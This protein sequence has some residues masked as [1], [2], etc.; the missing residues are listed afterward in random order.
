MTMA[1]STSLA[2]VAVSP[3]SGKADLKAFVDFAWEAYKD[4]PAW[5]PPLK[6]EVHG[7]LT[8]GK[9]PFFEHAEAQ[10]F[11][12][13]RDGRVTGRISAHIDRL[14]LTMPS[15]QGMGPGTGNWGMFEALDGE[16]AVALIAAA[17]DW[18]RAKGMTRALGPISLSIWEEPGLL[19]QGHDHPP[20]VMMGHHR[21]QYQ[22][23]IEAAGYAAAK[24]LQTYEL[25]ITIEY[26][27][28]IQRI[29]QSGE[30][31]DRI[32]IRKVDKSKFDREA[33]IILGILNDAWG[34]NWGFVPITD[35]EVAFTGKK[36]KPIVFEDLIRI[37][38][39]DGEPVAFMM[40]LPDLN[41][42][43]TPLNGNLFPF[44]WAKLLWW[45]RKPKVRTMRVPLMGVVK[46][47]QA[48]R[49]ASQ[50]AFMMIEYIRRDAI[51]KFGA[52]RGEIGWVLED[53][54]GMNA[55]AEAIDSKVNKVYTVYE[56]AL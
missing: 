31:N 7:M 28:L 13:R 44:G 1:Q 12:A 19:T 38:E 17:E 34:D 53:N 43:L 16:S 2:E 54:Q 40:T 4:D 36:L 46:R 52:T 55:I 51:S 18:L 37:A 27:P 24:L 35:T 42:A 8:P 30:K 26:P 14:A 39:L 45:L 47:L 50:L 23:W 3:V 48:S 41:E 29:I 11:L 25:D 22:G 5:V 20:T 56:K 49:M 9:N 10:Y 32:R 33:A 6:D 21:P 15:E